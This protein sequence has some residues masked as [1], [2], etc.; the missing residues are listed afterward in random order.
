MRA[1]SRSNPKTKRQPQRPT[2]EGQASVGRRLGLAGVTRFFSRVPD[3][4]TLLFF[5]ALILLQTIPSMMQE[6]LTFDE[7][8]RQLPGY[9]H[10]TAGEY[11]IHTAHPPLVKMIAALPL[12]FTGVRIPPLPRE[13]NDTTVWLFHLDFLYR[14]NDADRVVLLGRLAVLPLTLLLGF[15][16]FRWSKDHF[17]RGAATFALFLCSFEPN[18]LAH[19]RLMNTDLPVA[20]FFFLSVYCFFRL[21]QAATW[22]RLVLAGISLGLALV[23]KYTAVLAV[24]ILVLLGVGFALSPRPFVLQLRGFPRTSVTRRGRKLLFLLG[25]LVVLGLIAYVVI[26]GTYRF[27]YA[28]GTAAGYGY[29]RPWEEVLPDR[30]ATRAV[31]LWTR[32]M[33]LLPEAYVY[34]LSIVSTRVRRLAFL[35]GETSD[36]GWWYYFMVTFLLKTPIPLLLLLGLA[37]A[38]VRA[39]W[40]R[41]G[42]EV[43]FLLFPPLVYLAIASVGKMNIGHRHLLPVYPFFFVFISALIPWVFQQKALLKGTMAVLAAWYVFSSVSIFPHYLAYFNEL[44][45]GPDGG[46]KYLVDSNLDWGQDLK[47]L[48]RYMDAHGISRI[49][50]SYFGTASPEY[51]GI[52]YNALPSY[53]FNFPG[54][55]TVPTP[56]MAI[57]A[58]N[59]QGVYL[60]ALGLDPDYFKAFRDKQPVAKIGYSIFIYSLE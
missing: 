24:P 13:W 36:E 55:E 14:E 27:R 53:L 18:I 59:L 47:G 49:W 5:L 3:W 19:G 30:P 56:Y 29:Q 43:F 46:Y 1:V 54:R 31:I 21:T 39:S 37:I 58:T 51:Y 52:A 8:V 40:K 45:G 15:L 28:G 32:E 35:M 9:L 38:L 4:A 33:R 7:M 42:V 60:P 16:V 11:R 20:T 50:L 12:L 2:S 6:S 44:A 22:A 25:A 17:G 23:T 41:K 10:L 57:S 26:W 34:G 48:K